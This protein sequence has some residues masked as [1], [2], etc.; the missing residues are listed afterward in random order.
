DD[1]H[2]AATDFWQLRDDAALGRLRFP[3]VAARFSRSR[4][5][6]RRLPPRLGEHS[7]E[8]LR[9]A[10]YSEAELDGMIASGAVVQGAAPEVRG[11][12]EG[13]GTR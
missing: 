4:G 6:I 13:E 10:G 8:I 12:D 1:A 5:G 11:Q 7:A 9:E 2:L 3:G